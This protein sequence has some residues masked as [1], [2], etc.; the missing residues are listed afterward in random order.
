MSNP[1]TPSAEHRSP[2]TTLL[3]QILDP[4]NIERAWQR[5]KANRGAAGIDKMTVGAFPEFAQKHLPRILDQI[6]EGRYKPAAVRRTWIP[7][8]NGEKRPLGIP[9]VLDRV[10]QQAVA[11]VLSPIFDV[12]FS[13]QSYGFR[14]G[15]QAQAAVEHIRTHSEQGYRWGVDCDLKS[16]FDTVNHDLLMHRIGQGIR[17]KRVLKLIGKYLRAGVRQE[18]GTTTPTTKGVPQGGPLSPLL[19]N[20]MLDPLDKL[21]ESMGL[22]FA[23]YAD[24]FL[25]LAHDKAEALAAMAAVT[26]FVECSLRLLVNRDKSQVAPL[27]ACNFLGFQVVGK[28]VRRTDKAAHRFKERVRGVTSRSRGISMGQR[29]K[30]LRQYCVGWFHYFK[31]GLAYRE[32]HQWDQWIR[33]RVRLCYWKQWKL[34]RKR[35]RMLLKL[36]IPVSEVHKASRSR[37]GYWRMSNNSLV[38]MALTD[39]YLGKQGVPSMR[40]LWVVF[41]YGDKADCLKSPCH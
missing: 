40:V 27:K 3:D 2:Q 39:E 4:A 1:A 13:E 31:H 11:Q 34:P 15:R 29:L 7:K 20:I 38:Q 18:D 25:I 37:K 30:E 21:V 8:P 5:V 14:H 32:M 16:Y 12:D 19:A 10:I 9:T 41:K 23:R 28:K 17:D 26:Q 6:R 35:R 22:P 24:D 36:G 33:R